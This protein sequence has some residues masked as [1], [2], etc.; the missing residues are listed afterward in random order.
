M[1]DLTRVVAG[2]SATRVL[3]DLGAEVI[4]VEPPEGDL[5]RS[6]LAPPG[7]HRRCCSPARTSASASSPSTSTG[8]RASSWCCDLA[9][10]CD[11]VVEN[12]RPGVAARLGVGY[13]QVRARAARRRLLLGLR[14]RPGRPGRAAPGLRPR[15]ARRGRPAGPQGQGAR[16]GRPPPSR[17][18]TPTSPSGWPAPRRVLAALF[19]RER[20]RGRRLDRRLDVRGHAGHQRV[21]RGGGQRRPRLRAD[22]VPPGSGRGR[23]ARRR[24]DG[25]WVAIPGSPAAVLRH[26]LRLCGPGRAARRRALRHDGGPLRPPR[27]LRGR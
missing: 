10:R 23:A 1:L 7:R 9:E 13:E 20:R 16:T 18:P 22:P 5:L 2:P 4:K 25:T 11:V 21:D 19:R 3:A 27:R 15:R 6:R 26:C 17:S 14:L 24:R 8:P 12:F